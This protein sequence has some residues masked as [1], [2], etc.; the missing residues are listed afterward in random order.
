MSTQVVEP[1]A[2]EMRPFHVGEGVSRDD[3]VVVSHSRKDDNLMLKIDAFFSNP[4]NM[5]KLMPFLHGTN[6][7][8]RLI[9]WF[10]SVYAMENTVD[11]FLGH[12]YF[13]VYMDYQREMGEHKKQ[14]FDP[15]GRKWRKQKGKRVYYGI[16]FYYT[17]E[18]YVETTV[19]QLNFFKWFIEKRVL[20]YVAEHH[21]ELQSEMLKYTREKKREKRAA[22]V[23]EVTAVAA[24]VTNNKNN[25]PQKRSAA[26]EEKIPTKK[27]G[28]S[29]RQIR[30]QAMKRVTMKNVEVYVSFD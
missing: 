2:R 4:E 8:L 22:L 19:A 9:E 6:I 30:V 14:R 20:D 3:V 21:D 15:F 27:D 18:D 29:A 26:I 5:A 11:Y 24:A 25:S 17:D 10:V 7:S 12:E 23:A 16:H 28:S 13:N 1:P